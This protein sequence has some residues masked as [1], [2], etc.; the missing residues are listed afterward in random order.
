MKFKKKGIKILKT[1]PYYIKSLHYFIKNYKVVRNTKNCLKWYTK[2]S[3]FYKVLNKGLRILSSPTELCYLRLPFSDIFNS[4]KEIYRK[5]N[6]SYLF[7][8]KNK[9]IG[10]RGGIMSEAE[11]KDLKNNVGGFIEM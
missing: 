1:D 11:I 4:I 10:Y 7:K 2:D 5:T 9:F 3:F 6:Y 8:K